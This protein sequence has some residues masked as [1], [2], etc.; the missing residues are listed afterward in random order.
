[1]KKNKIISGFQKKLKA[2]QK[3]IDRIETATKRK[4][5]GFFSD[6]FG[7]YIKEGNFWADPV[8]RIKTKKNDWL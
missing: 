2:D 1:M 7:R 5:K 4:D 6:W 3:E 8:G